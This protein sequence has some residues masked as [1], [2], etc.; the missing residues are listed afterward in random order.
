QLPRVAGLLDRLPEIT[1]LT[2]RDH[3][4]LYGFSRGSQTANRFALSFPEHVAAV[5]LVSAGTYTLPF[6]SLK[7]S[8][9]DVAMPYPYGVANVGDLFGTGFNAAAFRS[10]PFWVAVG[11]RDTDPIDRRHQWD[12]LLGGDAPPP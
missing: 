7:L 10:V 1:G 6:P 2:V 5:A 11:G 9:A 3:A 12:R 8:D 4:L